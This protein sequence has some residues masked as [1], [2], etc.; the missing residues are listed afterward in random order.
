MA[1]GDR[2][3]PSARTRKTE[4]K[5]V[6]PPGDEAEVTPEAPPHG[7][8]A[9]APPGDGADVE[10]TAG[11]DLARAVAERDDYLAALQRL[12]AD[13]DNYRKRSMRQQTEVLERAT[14]SLIATLL[15]VLD[16]LD[17]A[18]AHAGSNAISDGDGNEP[19]ALS[20]IGTLLTDI[21]RREGLERIDTADVPFDP[22]VHD[23]VAHEVD[24]DG[25][26]DARRSPEISEVLR[27]GYRLKGR[28][29]RPAMVKVKG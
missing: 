23:A 18:R 28:V 21:L 24:E 27:A 17:L 22:N 11:E 8:E 3:E 14:E 10:S 2:R 12:Q 25:G 16:A 9:E 19:T 15:P 5:T 4:H 1:P 6:V 7:D 13:F 20:Q 29:L 26:E